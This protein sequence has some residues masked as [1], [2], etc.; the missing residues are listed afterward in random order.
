[1]KRPGRGWWIVAAALGIVLLFCIGIIWAGA[2]KDSDGNP[3][4]ENTS[5][6]LVGLFALVGSLGASIIATLT[7]KLKVITDN[8]QNDHMKPDGTPLGLRDDLD[9]KHGE[10][11]QDNKRRHDE[12]MAA[13]AAIAAAQNE[14][15]RDI[16]GLRQEN[17][18][19]R[20][21]SADRFDSIEDRLSAATDR[22][23]TI[24][25]RRNRP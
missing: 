21:A 12:Q 15:K 25:K 7:P 17:R 19:D 14:M 5:T 16:G 13:I 2:M 10:V 4:I 23:H 20:K 6:V 18:D 9:D 22:I 24:E 1:M 11:L 3:L 8:V